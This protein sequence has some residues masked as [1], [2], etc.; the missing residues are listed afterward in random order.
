MLSVNFLHKNMQRK[1]YYV[2]QLGINPHD[3]QANVIE[4][5]HFITL[6]KMYRI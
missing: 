1:L 3:N 6:Y 2:I 4:H 5:D